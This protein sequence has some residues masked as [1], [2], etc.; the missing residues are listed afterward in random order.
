MIKKYDFKNLIS[1]EENIN[2]IKVIDQLF[3]SGNWNKNI[4]HYQTWLDL[5]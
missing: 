2:C 3:E 4:P 1:L 5:F